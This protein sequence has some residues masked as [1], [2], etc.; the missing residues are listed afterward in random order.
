VRRSG[1]AA[2]NDTPRAAFDMLSWRANVA[3]VAALLT[4]SLIAWQVTIDQSISMRGMVMGLGQIGWL[5]Q[6]DMTAGVFLLMWVTMMVAM[7]LPT[8]AP[9]VL[10]HLGVSRRRGDGA[11]T[12]LVFVGGYLLVWSAIGFVPLIAY[13]A[14]A[15]ID[16]AAARSAWLPLVAGA[17]LFV[18]GAYQFAPWKRICFDH[19]QSPLAFIASHDFGRGWVGALRAGLVHGAYCLGCC[20]ALTAVLL[21]VGLMNLVWMAGIFAIFVV[22]KS[23]KHGLVVAKVAGGLLIGLGAAVIAHPALL[24]TISLQ[25]LLR[26]QT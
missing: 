24:A 12:T 9:V 19:C 10:A 26:L 6:G 22:E 1:A 8:T 11:W 4:V 7:M 23:W 13:R 20:W 17:I 21:A 2:G 18:A 15:H 14:V 3:I 25:P 16:A 5:S